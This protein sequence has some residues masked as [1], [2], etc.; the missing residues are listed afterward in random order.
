MRRLSCLAL[1]TSSRCGCWWGGLAPGPRAGCAP[2]QPCVRAGRQ[3][4]TALTLPVN[5]LDQKHSPIASRGTARSC[6][7]RGQ[8]R[9]S[10]SLQEYLYVATPALPVEGRR[11]LGATPVALWLVLWQWH[12][13]TSG[14]H[15]GPAA[16]AL[17]APARVTPSPMRLTA[18]SPTPCNTLTW[19]LSC[20]RPP[21]CPVHAG[22]AS[23]WARGAGG[24]PDAP[25][26]PS[27]PRPA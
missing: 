8:P 12:G 5:L 14:G 18:L 19:V 7:P 16:A 27:C 9:L 10:T 13:G 6:R 4:G 23:P 3:A 20:L 15:G 25:C 21:L 22:L 2:L 1:M 24:N 11:T 17:S 26:G